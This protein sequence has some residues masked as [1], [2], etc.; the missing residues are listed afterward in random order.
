MSTEKPDVKCSPY[1]AIGVPDI[2]TE[3]GFGPDAIAALTAFDT[4]NFQW[5]RMLEKGEFWSKI[6]EGVDDKLEHASLQGLVAVAK[7]SEGLWYDA[8]Q[9]PTIGLVAEA[10]AID[11]SRASRIVSDLVARDFLQRAVAQDDARKSILVLTDK[12]RSRLRDFTRRKWR[13]LGDVFQGWTE[14]EIT[15]FST[16]FARYVAGMG[17]ALNPDRDDQ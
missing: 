16:Q 17:K 15:A 4:A 11:P 2:L 1:A 6:N 7:I 13:L 9:P 3:Q 12:G 5:R 8:P 10:M 14:N